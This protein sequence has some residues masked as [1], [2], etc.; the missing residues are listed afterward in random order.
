MLV[1]VGNYNNIW[2]SSFFNPFRLVFTI[3]TRFDLELCDKNAK[4]PLVDPSRY[5]FGILQPA[6]DLEI[7]FRIRS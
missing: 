6:G 3:L 4:L 2:N 5:G 1:S 7:R